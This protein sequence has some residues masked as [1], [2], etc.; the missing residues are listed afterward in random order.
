[1]PI[2]LILILTTDAITPVDQESTSQEDEL[3][4]LSLSYSFLHSFVKLSFY[5]YN[6]PM[7]CTPV[8]CSKNFFYSFKIEFL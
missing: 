7:V 2:I 3:T 8:P 4:Y 6:P 1:M 5:F